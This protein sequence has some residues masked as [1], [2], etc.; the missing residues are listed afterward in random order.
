M[1][2]GVGGLR[3]RVG[4]RGKRARALKESPTVRR[5]TA[6]MRALIRDLPEL[7]LALIR[8]S[9][10]ALG[11]GCERCDRCH[12]TPLVGERVYEYESARMLCEL[13]RGERR[14]TPVSSRIVH[15]Q[16][17]GQ[18]VRITDQRTAA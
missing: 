14:E 3:R 7:E 11:A 8:R 9:V 5:M 16:E 17:F 2:F 6:S 15:G 1:G 10:G 13:C 4:L 18:A 12:R